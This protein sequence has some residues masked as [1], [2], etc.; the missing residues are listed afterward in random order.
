[1]LEYARAR[2]ERH[3]RTQSRSWICTVPGVF[4]DPTAAPS[5]A[6]GPVCRTLPRTR[7]KLTEEFER[8]CAPAL[9]LSQT[10][11]EGNAA[12]IP[13]RSGSWR[14]RFL[15]STVFTRPL[16]AFRILRPQTQI[17][18]PPI[19]PALTSIRQAPEFARTADGP[20]CDRPGKP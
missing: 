20:G 1:M 4:R 14:C 9:H 3:Q 6:L 18:L 19:A 12:A 11:T 17:D 8:F 2:S 15:S 5:S 16:H 13:F 10:E 7:R